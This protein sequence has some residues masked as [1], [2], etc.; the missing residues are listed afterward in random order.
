MPLRRRPRRLSPPQLNLPKG[1]GAI[2]GI[3]EKFSAN[4][5]TGTGSLSIALPLSPGRSGFG[6]KLSL[7]Y[8]SGAG[9]GIFGMGWSL[10][11]SSITRRT[12]KGL[13]KYRDDEE[14]DIF[15]LSGIR[16][17]GPSSRQRKRPNR[18]R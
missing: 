18:V 10:S 2:R 15:M 11:M 9:N 12:D 6:P 3:D 13:P 7:N 1:G 5:V 8:D 14:S 17:S 16:G 4:P